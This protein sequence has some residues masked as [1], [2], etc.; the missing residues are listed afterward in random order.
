VEPFSS[1]SKIR[2]F[3]SDQLLTPPTP[4]APSWP[5]TAFST[6]D[7]QGLDIGIA[8]NSLVY[9]TGRNVYYASVPAR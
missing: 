9:D 7:G 1:A 8:H 5:V 6:A 3:T 4:P 2:L